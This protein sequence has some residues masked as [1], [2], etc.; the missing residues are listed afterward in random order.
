MRAEREHVQQTGQ[1]ITDLLVPVPVDDPGTGERHEG[2]T[3]ALSTASCMLGDG[4]NFKLLS[5]PVDNY[6]VIIMILIRIYKFDLFAGASNGA[7]LFSRASYGPAYIW[8]SFCLPACDS[9][10][11]ELSLPNISLCADTRIISVSH[12]T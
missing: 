5:E 3:R 1:Q 7:E 10:V 6:T 9:V 8:A 11:S 12:S 2:R 4:L